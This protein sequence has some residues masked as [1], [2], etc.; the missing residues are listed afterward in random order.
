MKGKQLLAAFLLGAGLCFMPVLGYGE[1]KDWW[2]DE[3]KATYMELRLF[4]ARIDYM[5]RN[6]TTFLAVGFEYDPD[7]SLRRDFFPEHIGI[8][9][10]GKILVGIIDNR[11]VFSDEAGTD[12]LGGFQMELT[13]IYSFLTFIST[14]MNTDIV[15]KL[16]SREEV[17][18]AY[19]YQGEYHLWE[20]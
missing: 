4:N 2:Y 14:E 20:E 17:A 13:I 5:M 12:L 6:P 3:E 18:L 16:Y 15:A 11:G 8:D 9:T 10:K 19:F 1:V 7:G